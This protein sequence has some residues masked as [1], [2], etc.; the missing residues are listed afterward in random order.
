MSPDLRP[1]DLGTDD[2][3][4][5]AAVDEGEHGARLVIADITRDGAWLSIG[6]SEAPTLE[7]WR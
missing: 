6:E 4:V 3:E 7:S 2:R 5:V 1:A